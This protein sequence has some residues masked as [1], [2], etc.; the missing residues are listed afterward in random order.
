MTEI[1]LHFY[2][3]SAASDPLRPPRPQGRLAVGMDADIT[4]FDPGTV[5]DRAT[6]AEPS[7]PSAGVQFVL[8]NGTLVLDAGKETGALPG[9]AVRGQSRLS[10]VNGER[11]RKVQKTTKLFSTMLAGQNADFLTGIDC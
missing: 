9:R 11:R 6:L 3:I 4:A 1:H 8:V 10:A 5:L 2:S 7:L